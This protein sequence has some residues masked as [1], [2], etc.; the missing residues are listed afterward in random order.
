MGA[1]KQQAIMPIF[2][3]LPPTSPVGAELLPKQAYTALNWVCPAQK[4]HVN[5][6]TGQPPWHSSPLSSQTLFSPVIYGLLF[7]LFYPSAKASEQ[8]YFLPLHSA[9]TKTTWHPGSPSPPL[10]TRCGEWREGRT[11]CILACYEGECYC[12]CVHKSTQ[13]SLQPLWLDVGK[14]AVTNRAASAN[15]LATHWWPQLPYNALYV[16]NDSPCYL[17][18]PTEWPPE[19]CKCVTACS[20]L[21]QRTSS[22]AHHPCSATCHGPGSLLE[23]S[24]ASRPLP[25]AAAGHQF[26]TSSLITAESLASIVSRAQAW[27]HMVAWQ[28]NHTACHHCQAQGS[29]EVGGESQPLYPWW[30][31]TTS[32]L[33]QHSPAGR[34]AM[35]LH[36]VMVVIEK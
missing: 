33:L 13:L 14:I 9:G 1:I 18:R 16:Q 21:M 20:A 35:L 6:E 36:T 30:G 22:A 25:D 17:S 31:D 19:T 2:T 26:F 4:S 29:K 10:A 5:H 28:R 11:Y 15:Q 3:E 24:A 7:L 32:P 27:W 12:Y 23:A 34:G 8:I